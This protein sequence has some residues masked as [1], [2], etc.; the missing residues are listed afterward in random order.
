MSDQEPRP[1][2]ETTHIPRPGPPGSQGLPGSVPPP[3][4]PPGAP[5]PPPPPTPAS[6]GPSRS[7]SVAGTPARGDGDLTPQ[8]RETSEWSDQLVAD[9]GIPIVDVPM[10]TVGGGFGSFMVADHLRIAGA[11]TDQLRVLTLLDAPFQQYRYLA[12][13]SQI[14]DSERIR[15]DSQSCPDNIWGFPSYA[16]REAWEDKKLTSAIGVLTEPM[17]AEFYTPRSGQVYRTTSKEAGRIGWD[18][19]VEKGRVRMVRKRIGGGYYTILTPPE[20]STP[21]RRI[22]FRSHYVHLAVGYPGVKF[23][24]DLRDY[25]ERTNDFRRVVNAYEPHEHVY[26]SL[27]G[28]GGDV[29]VRGSGIVAS[30]ILKRL[31]DDVE[32]RGSRTRI[33]HLFRTY[34]EGSE[35]PP[36]FRRESKLGWTYQAFNF[37]KAA[38]GGQLRERLIDAPE[39]DRP[40]LIKSYGGTNT[41]FHAEWVDQIARGRASG[42]YQVALGVV[43]EVVDDG[44]GRIVTHVRNAEGQEYAIPADFIIDATGLEGD[45]RESQLLDDL[46]THT[47]AQPNPMG[48]LSVSESFEVEGTRNATGRL[49][50]SGSMTLGG[51]YAPVDSFLGLQYCA[52]QIADDLASQGFVP[53]LGTFR[54]I[55]QWLKWARGKQP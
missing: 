42:A 38:W 27:A 28:S 11:T 49:Y 13:N 8:L 34:R 39:K 1:G 21:T 26:D 36:K 37:P 55:G 29:V 6:S 41:A 30:R 48:R 45:V 16:L 5:P 2:D 7:P 20:G 40:D 25:R 31:L 35:G 17:F 53:R 9:A 22:A 43:N 23:L 12:T 52:L 10:V 15:S 33:W 24:P 18:K 54:S 47:G 50:A 32:Q 4:G 46:L 14:P 51:P 44:S 3:P 19:M